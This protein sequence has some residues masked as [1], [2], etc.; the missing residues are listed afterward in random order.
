MGHCQ[1]CRCTVAAEQWMGRR[2]LSC[3]R[4][5]GAGSP[6]RSRLAAKSQGRVDCRVNDCGARQDVCTAHVTTQCILFLDLRLSR[7]A[8]GRTL[9]LLPSAA[10][11]SRCARKGR[12]SSQMGGERQRPSRMGGV[13]GYVARRPLLRPPACSV[14]P[15]PSS[16]SACS[17]LPTSNAATAGTP[18]RRCAT[19]AAWRRSAGSTLPF[20]SP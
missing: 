15:Q 6:E 4:T 18:R 19:L 8:G 11:A 1:R 12:R 14:P 10:S 9:S 5:G 20:S 17:Q 16:A 2:G 3:S 13:A 7:P